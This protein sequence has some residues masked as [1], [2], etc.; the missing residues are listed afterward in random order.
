V[1]IPSYRIVSFDRQMGIGVAGSMQAAVGAVA[2]CNGPNAPYCVPNEFICVEIARFLRLPMP[3][4]GIIN[5]PAAPITQWFASLDFNLSGNALAPID[6]MRSFAALPD[7]C[8]GLLLFDVLIANCD[9]HRGNLSIN[10]AVH[11]PQMAVFDHSHAL[12][13]YHDGRG[14][15]RLA[16]MRDR[17]AIS[18][19]SHTGPNRHCLLDAISTD[20]HMRKWLDRIAALPDFF[21]EDICNDAASLGLTAAEAQDVIGFLKARRHSLHRIIE[22]NRDEFSAIKDWRLI[23]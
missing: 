6:P 11:P 8:T 17:L 4:S 2:K 12:F 5:A 7:E 23:L 9:R 15:D 18:G 19:G 20:S 10:F 1:P 22:D 3:P 13:G 21:I 14:R 16:Q